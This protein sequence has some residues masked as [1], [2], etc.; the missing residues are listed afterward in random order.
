MYVEGAQ[1]QVGYR[2]GVATEGVGQEVAE[3]GRQVTGVRMATVV[4]YWAAARTEV[5]MRARET[6][7]EVVTREVAVRV[8]VAKEEAVRVVA[9]APGAHPKVSRAGTSVTEGVDWEMVVADLD[10]EVVYWAAVRMGVEMRVRE[11]AKEVVTREVV[12]RVA[13]AKEEAARV[14]AVAPVAHPKVSRVGTSVTEGAD[15]GAAG[16]VDW[17]M[18]VVCREMD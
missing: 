4:G 12:V 5:E 11:T 1:Y 6:A 17:A 10:V 8:A 18:V 9:V 16:F 3:T 15:W 14:V 13:V 2:E 7:K